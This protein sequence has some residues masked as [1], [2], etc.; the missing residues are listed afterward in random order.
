[1]A[2]LRWTTD[3]MMGGY[4]I[5]AVKEGENA[6]KELSNPLL[7]QIASRLREEGEAAEEQEPAYSR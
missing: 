3:K 4:Q 2:I 6:A 7:A 1:M 5:L